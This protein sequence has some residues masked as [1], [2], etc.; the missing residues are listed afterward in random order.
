MTYYIV[1]GW[2]E[3]RWHI[4]E[5]T[6][7]SQ[8]DLADKA[9]TA[10]IVLAHSSGCY[11]LPKL[12][13]KKVVLVDP[14]YWPGR[15]M[16]R[17]MFRHVIADV[18]KQIS[19]YGLPFWLNMRFHNTLYAVVAPL[20][21]TIHTHSSLKKE[22]ASDLIDCKVIII[23]N[24]NDAYCSSDVEQLASKKISVHTLAGLHED[25][26]IEPKQLITTLVNH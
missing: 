7:R 26:W 10:D 3:G 17:R 2:S 23:R 18:P 11:N 5:F 14:P 6:R 19:S 24:E 21:H 4:K 22:L 12:K 16:L 9:E 1:P 15:S 8:I 25:C 13:N 20:K